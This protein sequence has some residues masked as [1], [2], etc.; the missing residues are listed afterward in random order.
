MTTFFQINIIVLAFLIYCCSIKPSL[1]MVHQFSNRI[2]T[3]NLIRLFGLTSISG[4]I[5]PTVIATGVSTSE[6]KVE[7]LGPDPNFL[8][9]NYILEY[10]ADN[11]TFYNFTPANK[12]N[13]VNELLGSPLES[14]AEY[15]FRGRLQQN[16]LWSDPSAVVCFLKIIIFP[17]LFLISLFPILR[18]EEFSA[19]KIY[20]RGLQWGAF[21]KSPPI[22]AALLLR[23][24]PIVRKPPVLKH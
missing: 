12:T 21:L 22:T 20:K 24:N 17:N 5:A 1:K 13:D 19:R 18:V 9:E 10:S 3:K 15:Y 8:F 7:I 23:S 4:T 6:I 14:A 11:I 2:V 16:G